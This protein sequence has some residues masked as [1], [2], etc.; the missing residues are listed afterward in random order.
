MEVK[1]I[2]ADIY[3]CED[4]KIVKNSN[5]NWIFYRNLDWREG[6]ACGETWVPVYRTCSTVLAWRF[7]KN[8]IRRE[9][10]LNESNEEDHVQDR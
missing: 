2:K 8:T 7:I 6:Q 5:G 9:D 1:C 4:R 3:E 10:L